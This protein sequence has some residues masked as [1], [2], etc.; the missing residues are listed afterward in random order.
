MI[1]INGG[2]WKAALLLEVQTVASGELPEVLDANLTHNLGIT[3]GLA[4]EHELGWTSS[5]GERLSGDVTPAGWERVEA[6]EAVAVIIGDRELDR[7]Q[8][9]EGRPGG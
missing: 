2:S 7:E 8:V 3:H 4:V 6:G 1:L 5:W 9:D